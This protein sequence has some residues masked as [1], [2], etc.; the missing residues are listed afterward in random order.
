L[1]VIFVF[2]IPGKQYDALMKAIL[3]ILFLLL[4]TQASAQESPEIL[5]K[6]A[7]AFKSERKCDEALVVL[8]KAVGQKPDYAEALYEMGWCYNETQQFGLAED[9]LRKSNQLKKGQHLTNYELG[10]ALAHLN[11]IDEALGF[12]NQALQINPSFAQAY[13][14][15]GDLY[16]D[17][18]ENTKEALV[19][20][21]Q[22]VK[23][24]TSYKKVYYWIG[25]CYND[26]EQYQSA[27]PYLQKAITFETQN[28]LSYTELGFSYYSM[29][30]YSN[31]VDILIKSDA[32][33]PKFDVT[34]YYLGLSYI[35]MQRKA[36]AVKRYNDL[37]LMGSEYAI[38][39][40]NEIKNMK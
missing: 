40:L 23:L 32:L 21:V 36:D 7:L 28:Y 14:A 13:I 34:L 4:F 11:K 5:Y 15:K 17:Y 37:I 38:N 19:N 22:A 3:P 33:K 24:D 6:K 35:K 12:Y 2:F 18:K 39:L 30:Q 26:L 31:A 9:V 25:W 27:I 10:L 16:K 8:K 1:E 20:Y 29:Q